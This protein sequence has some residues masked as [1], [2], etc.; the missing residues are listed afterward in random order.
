[1]GLGLGSEARR[2]LFPGQVDDLCRGGGLFDNRFRD[3]RLDRHRRRGWRCR[4][5]SRGFD[6]RSHD[7][8]GSNG[9][10]PRR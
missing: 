5:G 8:R 7:R 6:G 3:A 2:R 1:L 10:D 4:R 9:S